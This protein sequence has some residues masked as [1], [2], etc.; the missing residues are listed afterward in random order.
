MWVYNDYIGKRGIILLGFR[1]GWGMGMHTFTGG[2]LMF[3][4]WALIIVGIVY[5][6]KNINTGS[7]QENN[8]QYHSKKDKAIEI[9]RERYA[10]GEI[11][12]EEFECLMEDLK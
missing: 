12:K 9:A 6:I 2:I 8:N 10:N 3:L 7:N 1:H 5:L 11:S 4:F